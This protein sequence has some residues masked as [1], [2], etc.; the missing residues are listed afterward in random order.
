MMKANLS[1][2]TFKRNTFKRNTIRV[3]ALT[4]CL[5]IFSPAQAAKKDLEQEITIKS[6]RQ[7]ADLKNKIASYLDNVSIRQGSISITADI[8]K[9]FSV[10]DKKTGDKNDTYL[11][12]GKPAIFQQK[13]ED[14]SLI[15]LQ[16]DEITY[17][18]TSHMITITGNALVKQAGSE[19]SGNEITYNTL[20]EKLEAKSASNQS[21]TTVLQPTILKKQKETYEK[22]KAEK[23]TEKVVEK[24]GDNRDN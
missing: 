1:R 16:A 12:K 6:Q 22:S 13:L 19:V 4:S 8:V 3:L 9:V 14:G 7:A 17:S 23:V 21:V 15:K 11:A 5:F 10:V 20:N 2:I 24:K 18:P